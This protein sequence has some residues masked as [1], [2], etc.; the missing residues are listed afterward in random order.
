MATL[1]L[2]RA[3]LLIV[4]VILLS[5]LYLASLSALALQLITVQGI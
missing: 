1:G 2:S 3:P 4:H 5:L